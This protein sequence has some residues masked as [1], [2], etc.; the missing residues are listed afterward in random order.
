MLEQGSEP[1]MLMPSLTST[2]V[3]EGNSNEPYAFRNMLYIR[4]PQRFPLE[5][6]IY[7][8]NLQAGLAGNGNFYPLSHEV[9]A[10]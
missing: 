10:V 6:V 1:L 4:N 2:E 7:G 3:V 9:S 8:K 5:P